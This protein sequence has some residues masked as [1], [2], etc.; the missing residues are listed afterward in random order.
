MFAPKIGRETD[1]LERYFTTIYVN[2]DTS[3]ITSDTKTRFIN[4]SSDEL[5]DILKEVANLKKMDNLN[6]YPNTA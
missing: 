4:L 2:A 5:V 3:Q 1:T 6:N